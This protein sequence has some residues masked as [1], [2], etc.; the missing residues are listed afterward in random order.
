MNAIEDLTG[1]SEAVGGRR[2]GSS[3]VKIAILG[4][5]GAMGG[6]FGAYLARAGEEV[7][8]VDISLAAVDAINR[9][10]LVLE[11]RDGSTSIIP[12]K[13]S[14]KPEEI[15]P[16]DL[17][18][19]FVKCYSTEVAIRSAAPLLGGRTAILT[20]QNGWGNA[21]RIAA[22]AGQQ[23][24]MV[25]LT[26]HSGTLL[27][28]GWVKQSGAGMTNSTGRRRRAWMLRSAHFDGRASKRP[29]R[30]ASS[31]RFGKSSP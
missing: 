8:L 23:R 14:A 21:D 28:P 31:T 16:V 20:L 3:K 26:Y 7:V 29:F 4:R 30:R 2:G 25:G 18:I 15:G 27:S 5:G 6:M 19:N 1:D 22:V 24:V 11:E 9:D 17:I 12:V 10:G 13:A